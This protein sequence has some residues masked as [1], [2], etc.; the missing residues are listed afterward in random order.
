M[1]S[2]LSS[3]RFGRAIAILLLLLFPVAIL[4]AAP[5]GKRS[6]VVVIHGDESIA[7][8]G[9]R[10]FALSL[11]KHAVRWYREGGLAVDLADD[12]NL[13]ADLANRKVAVLVYCNTPNS[14][15]MKALRAFTKRGGKLIVTFSIS[16]DLAN[17]MDI[18]QGAYLRDPTGRFSSMHFIAQ[19]P[20]NIPPNILQSSSNII[21]AFPIKGKSHVLAWW[22]DRAGRSTGQAAWLESDKGFWMTHVLLAD[23]DSTAKGRLLVALAASLAPELWTEAARTRLSTQGATGPWKNPGD[24]LTQTA[25]RNPSPR[26][27][28]VRRQ[29]Q[30]ADRTYRE[31]RRLLASKRAPEAWL[32]ANELDRMMVDAYGMMQRP[33]AGEIHAVWDHSGQG[34]YPGDW[35]R[36]CRALKK[37]G[38]TDIFVN[39]AGAGFAHCALNALP[40]STVYQT[41]GDQLSQCIQAAH[42]LGIR[43]H[44]WLICFSTTLATP[45]RMEIYRRKGWLLE[46]TDGTTTRWLDPSEYG[47]RAQLVRAAE[48]LLIKYKIDG[49]HL[50]F[51]RYPDYYPSL[52]PGTRDRFNASRGKGRAVKK[53]PE[54]V[55]RGALFHELVRWRATQVTA[56]VADLRVMQRRKAPHALIT[57]AVLG[58]YPTCVESVG[59]DWISWLRNDY[60]DFAVPMNYTESEK[61]YASLLAAQLAKKSIAHRIIGG[62][63]VTASESRLDAAQVID[64]IKGL[65]GGGAAGFA[66][67][68]L[69]TMLMNRILPVLRLG[70]TAPLTPQRP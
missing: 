10:G 59:Q 12:K 46:A 48:E 40:R 19:R 57:A 56:F 63:G 4:Q 43:V 5:T 16:P 44:A 26:I 58:K 18:K 22:I 45:N 6:S 9:E 21:T 20:I 29:L 8:A 52:G 11:A 28:Q 55:K 68:D 51:V 34:L 42:P 70:I 66:L 69:D 36:T 1:F 50:D 41:M 7:A 67:F 3:A 23:G 65:R 39:V 64:Q 37:A 49:L 15:Q 54:D 30:Q 61:T 31:A 32:L 60:I 24:G 33:I 13:T 47:A 38:I 2:I 62:I 14:K 35:P 27:L 53:W 25:G 17:L